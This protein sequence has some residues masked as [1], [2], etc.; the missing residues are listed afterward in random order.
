MTQ[1]P[2]NTEPPTWTQAPPGTRWRDQD[3]SP[4]RRF[5]GGSP[6]GVAVK[7]VLVSLIVG[8]AL[9]WLHI[10]PTQL[11]QEVADLANRLALL[12][13]QSLHD[14]GAYITAGAMIV[15]PVWLILRLLSYRGR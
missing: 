15:I 8:A 14:F 11:V 1:R 6:L 3:A 7:L 9:M 4:L 5:I 10:S 12:G 2:P 13:F